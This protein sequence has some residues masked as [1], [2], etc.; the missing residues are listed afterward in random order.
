VSAPSRE[1]WAAAVER[2]VAQAEAQGLPRHVEDPAT[3]RR[4]VTLLR[5]GSAPTRRRSRPR[6]ETSSTSST[7]PGAHASEEH[8]ERNR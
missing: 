1:E 3:V 8:H 6:E 2:L 5:A 4:L 7:P